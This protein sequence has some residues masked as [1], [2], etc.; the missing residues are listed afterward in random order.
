MTYPVPCCSIGT[1]FRE[2]LALV[3]GEC[4]ARLGQ[5]WTYR[6]AANI[7]KLPELLGAAQPDGNLLVQRN[8]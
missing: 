6:I 1:R 2:G 5:E 4:Q 7:A 3:K 8:R